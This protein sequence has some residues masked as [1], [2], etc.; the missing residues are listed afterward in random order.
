MYGYSG[1]RRW[2]KTCRIVINLVE[3]HDLEDLWGLKIIGRSDDRYLVILGGF[4]V[5]LRRYA[6]NNMVRNFEKR[7]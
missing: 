1:C 2:H 3:R 5:D 4:R 7:A 6:V